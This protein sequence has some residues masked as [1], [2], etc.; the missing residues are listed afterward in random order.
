MKAHIGKKIKE[1][2]EKSGMSVTDFAKRISYSRRNIYAIFKKESIDTS[3]LKRISDV[4]EHDFFA[5]YN[6]LIEKLSP[7]SNEMYSDPPAGYE[8]S[9]MQELRKEVEYLKEFNALLRAQN[10]LLKA[11]LEKA[12]RKKK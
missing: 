9:T 11:Q 6:Q 7:P 1:A 2:V 5:N 4:L 3:L 10:V 8:N 12:S